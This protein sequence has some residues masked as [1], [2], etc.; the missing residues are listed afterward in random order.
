MKTNLLY[1]KY[2]INCMATASKSGMMLFN[3]PSKK[4]A[5]RKNYVYGNWVLLDQ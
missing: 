5:N 3:K 1:V 4:S 2:R